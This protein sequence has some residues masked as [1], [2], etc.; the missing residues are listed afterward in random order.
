VTSATSSGAEAE[1]G[2]LSTSTVKVTFEDG[3]AWVVLNRPEKRNAMNPARNRDMNVILDALEI[4]DRCKVLVLTGAGDAFT[5]GMDL[6]EFFRE[7]AGF[8][9]IK[10][11]RTMAQATNWQ[12]RKLRYFAKPTIAMVNGWT[13]GGGFLPL[14]ACDLA[15]AADDATFGVSEINWGIIPAGNVTKAIE[16]VLNE[17]QA[18]RYI[19]T[20]DP[21]DGKKAAEIGLVTE[22]VPRDQLRVTVVALAQKLMKK[23]PI[24]LW[25]AK[26]AF[27]HIGEMDWELS[28]EY[29]TAKAIA[30]TA[31]DP[32]RGSERGLKQFLD[33]KSYKPGLGEYQREE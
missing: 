27:K 11:R 3:I 6:R 26:V 19:M 33:D 22:A 20:G 8:D 28:E 24:T 16:A 23:N 15:I 4:D 2:E 17:R 18:L 21:F 31:M 25:N 5:A 32:E 29:L 30:N 7:T 1:A 14:V 13:F 9:P 10:R 12:W